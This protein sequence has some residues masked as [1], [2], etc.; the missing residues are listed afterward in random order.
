MATLSG[1]TLSNHPPDLAAS[2]VPKAAAN[3]ATVPVRLRPA[4]TDWVSGQPWDLF[5][6]MTPEKRTHP[7]ALL[8]R[9][10]YCMNKASDH[11]YGRGWDRRGKGLQWLVGMERFKSG[12]PHCHALVRFP[13]LALN[14]D[15]GKEIFN[16]EYW[17]KFFTETGGFVRLDQPRSKDHCVA[18]VTKYVLKEGEI[19]WSTN[20][21]FPL[22][23]GIQERLGIGGAVRE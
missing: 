8:K 3:K 12:W 9:Y 20:C 16:L 4:W 21:T 6:T 5:V 14:S 1:V 2:S 13:D 15:H 10:R 11:V 17:Q 22:T 7:E 18:Y 23:M 19:T